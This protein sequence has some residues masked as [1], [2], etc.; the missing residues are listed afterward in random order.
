MRPEREER[1]KGGKAVWQQLRER[2][3]GRHCFRPAR[4]VLILFVCVLFDGGV[5]LPRVGEGRM[6]R[7]PAAERSAADAL[8]VRVSECRPRRLVW[9]RGVRHDRNSFVQRRD[10]WLCTRGEGGGM[11]VLRCAALAAPSLRALSQRRPPLVHTS[12]HPSTAV[13]SIDAALRRSHSSTPPAPRP[14]LRPR[15]LAGAAPLVTS[16]PRLT[17][18]RRWTSMRQTHTQPQRQ[19]EAKHARPPSSPPPPPLLLLSARSLRAHSASAPPS[20]CPASFALTPAATAPA[21]A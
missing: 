18:P 12:P 15:P 19:R 9:S 1:G 17:P 10:E 14:R 8:R 13:T 11:R 7:L 20:T 16:P 3:R 2:V 6:R 21:A 5:L 4:S